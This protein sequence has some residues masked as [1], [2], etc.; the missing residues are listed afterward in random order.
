M[1]TFEEFSKT[2]KIELSEF[3][4]YSWKSYKTEAV[5]DGK[6]FLDKSNTDLERWTNLLASS[7]LTPDDYEW[8]LTSKKDL[9]E[10]VALKRKG[11]TKVAL[12]R[13]TNG[14]IDTIVATA[15]KTFL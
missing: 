6:A 14:L 5:K 1:S 15:F 2:L 12:D 4:E 10:L 13:F 7:D 3:A 8:L 9:A 11:L